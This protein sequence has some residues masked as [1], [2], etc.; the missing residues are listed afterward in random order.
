VL[1]SGDILQVCQ[2]RR[3]VSFMYS[4][5]NYIPLP[6]AAVRRAVAAVEP[7]AFDWIYG[8]MF[9]LVIEHDA[10]A[11]V[12]RSADRYLRAIGAEEAGG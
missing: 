5:P 2:D 6:A 1:L 3:H 10:K 4:Y 8:F 7:F 12:S 11:A 9:D